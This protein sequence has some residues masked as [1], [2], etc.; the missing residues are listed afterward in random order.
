MKSHTWPRKAVAMAHETRKRHVRTHE[1]PLV[2]LAAGRD[3]DARRPRRWAAAS[4][5]ADLA[6]R[7]HLRHDGEDRLS[8]GRRLSRSRH[9]QHA[10]HDVGPDAGAGHA[11]L[12]HGRD[13][14]RR[15]RPLRNQRGPPRLLAGGSRS[16]PATMA[17]DPAGAVVFRRQ[18]V[19][20][21]SARRLDAAADRGRGARA[22]LGA[23]DVA[24]RA[25]PRNPRRAS[26][27][28]RGLDQAACG[29]PGGRRLDVRVDRP[30]LEADRGRCDRGPSRRPRGRGGRRRLARRHR[31]LAAL[32]RVLLRLESGV[33]AILAS[34]P[35]IRLQVLAKMF[36]SFPG[37]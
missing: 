6:R 35:W 15:S 28:H 13:P 27:G 29:R 4:A 24:Q 25:G 33:R 19:R 26:V 7:R 2:S 32:R 31:G 30:A 20:S 11:R 23:D 1:L 5:D 14:G 34:T 8:G 22:R 18:R 16:R 21:L 3:P 9:Q 37:T 12:E 10:R 36:G 17:S